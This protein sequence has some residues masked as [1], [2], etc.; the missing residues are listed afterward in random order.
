MTLTRT[1]IIGRIT[2]PDDTNPVNSVVRFIMT[3]F[4]TD[5]TE[6]ATIIQ[7]PIDAAIDAL[8]D[9]D[10]NL[11]PN[12]LGVR[13]T[14]YSTYARIPDGNT[15]DVI[16]IYLGQISVPSTGGPYDLNDLLPIAPPAGADVADYIAQLAAAATTASDSA[17]SA[18]SSAAQAALYEGIWL[19]DA[20]AV[21]ADTSLTYTPAQPSTVTAGDYVRTRNEG[22]SYIVADT[23]AT[24]YHAITAGSVKLYAVPRDG[25]I[26]A[27]QIGITDGSNGT[28]LFTQLCASNLDGITRFICDVDFDLAS[29]S[30]TGFTAASI[31]VLEAD[32]FEQIGHGED[33]T[34]TIGLMN[35]IQQR[36]DANGLTR[37]SAMFDAAKFRARGLRFA[38]DVDV[39]EAEIT[40]NGNGNAVFYDI[41]GSGSGFFIEKC[42][43]EFLSGYL[44]RIT[45]HTFWRV[46][47]CWAGK[48]FYFT[49]LNGRCDYGVFNGNRGVMGYVDSVGTNNF[50]DYIKV[51]DSSTDGFGSRYCSV[52]ENYFYN[53]YRD[54]IDSTG[55][56]H[57]WKITSNTFEC[58]TAAI[59]AKQS[60]N[61]S[62]KTNSLELNFNGLTIANNVVKGCE[63]IFTLNESLAS[64]GSTAPEWMHVHG[65]VANGNVF[66]PKAGRENCGYYLK[67]M[68]G[69]SVTG[70]NFTAYRLKKEADFDPATDGAFPANAVDGTYYEAT[71]A[72]TIDGLAISIGDFV[73]PIKDGASTSDSADWVIKNTAWLSCSMLRFDGGTISGYSNQGAWDA[74]AGS[75]P[76]STADG[77]YWTVSVAG[78]VDGIRFEV[79]N[80]L[81]ALID[82][83]STSVYDANWIKRRA[84]YQ[85]APGTN[86]SFQDILWDARG[87]AVCVINECENVSL[88]F[89][90][91]KT[92]SQCL[93]V[94][95]SAFNTKITGRLDGYA[96]EFSPTDA[97]SPITVQTSDV[98][99]IDIDAEYH[100]S[101]GKSYCIVCP[102]G[103]DPLLYV[104]GA[105]ENWLSAVR[106]QDPITQ[107]YFGMRNSLRISNCTYLLVR[108]SEAQKV[109]V[110]LI[111][112]KNITGLVTATALLTG[113]ILSLKAGV[114]PELTISGG[115]VT[116]ANMVHTVDTQSDA[117]ADD[118]VT[119]NGGQTGDVL[120]ISP[121][122]A[123]RVVTAKTGTGNLILGADRVLNE[124]GDTL[125]LRKYADGNWHQVD[126]FSVT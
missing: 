121:A 95:L 2:L 41:S 71:S 88:H 27:T 1:N 85:P 39:T 68:N 64:Y 72:A 11:W 92:D 42:R 110:G 89:A 80:F 13:T 118:L 94:R 101:D 97:V 12:P 69:L 28:T 30:D 43:A 75:F 90:G 93:D 96:N 34:R 59:D 29:P 19:D 9:I 36:A 63:F 31:I 98:I 102:P 117:A 107:S 18:A 65:I 76:A 51:G 104:D 45:N 10:V 46:T 3:S 55:G 26:T 70:D 81:V 79:G 48:Q 84:T 38:Y 47:D 60:P 100:S 123:A 66:V 16:S 7:I 82:S 20:P 124:L 87:T 86:V 54:G 122:D 22:F 49:Y 17:V 25:A 40:G 77:Q 15:N 78:T 8:G 37:R 114:G 111:H 106:Y 115:V 33:A 21:I 125:V 105:F 108:T 5:D 120:T 113:T 32:N 112:T 24:D 67:G 50:G 116:A 35:L 4:D 52:Y 74:S 58:V 44:V 126:F 119:I 53:E 14:F 56:L 83:A 61:D 103:F 57:G 91:V 6:N 109:D 23:A 73:I 99:Y 62:G